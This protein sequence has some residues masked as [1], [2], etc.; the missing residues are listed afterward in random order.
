MCEIVPSLKW[1][2]CP[3][4]LICVES[5]EVPESYNVGLGPFFISLEFVVLLPRNI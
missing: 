5:G 1:S 4:H 3:A 2:V